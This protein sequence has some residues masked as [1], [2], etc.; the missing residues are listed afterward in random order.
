MPTFSL[1]L[2]LGT[3]RKIIFRF[4]FLSFLLHC[5]FIRDPLPDPVIR[6]TEHRA[7]FVLA[8]LHVVFGIRKKIISFRENFWPGK[9]S[10]TVISPISETMKNGRKALYDKTFRGFQNVKTFLEAVC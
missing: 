6:H 7:F 8:P 2:T 3:D 9:P 5:L 4:C 1:V 10:K